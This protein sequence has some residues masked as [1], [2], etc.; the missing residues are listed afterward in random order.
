[1]AAARAAPPRV[2]SWEWVTKLPLGFQCAADPRAFPG[3]AR[4]WL[5]CV[6]RVGE[7]PRG[8]AVELRCNIALQMASD[9]VSLLR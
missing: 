7:G 3:A 1:M 4:R 5:R 2:A 9:R 8:A 6:R